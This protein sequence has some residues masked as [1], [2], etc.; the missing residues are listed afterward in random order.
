MKEKDSQIEDAMEMP[1]I[2]VT[3][4]DIINRLIK[5]FGLTS[6][7]E[8]NK[9]DGASYYDEIV[10]Q[11]KTIAYLPENSFLDADNIQRLLNIAK[12][13]PMEQIMTLDQLI[14]CYGSE[15]FD[16]IFFDPVHIRP[17]VD[18]ALQCLPR[19]LNPGGFL[20]VHDCNPELEALT[21][22][23]R[24]SGSWVGETYKAMTLFRH[25]NRTQ[26]VTVAEDHG[27]G[28]IYN[29]GLRLDYDLDFDIDYYE[30]AANRESYIGLMTFQAFLDRTANGDVGKLL[31][32]D[33]TSVSEPVYFYA[34]ASTTDKVLPHGVSS[35]SQKIVESQLFWCQADN[36]FAE[37]N[38]VINK[39]WL[40]GQSQTLRFTLPEGAGNLMCLRFDVFD[41][42]G[43]ATLEAV[44]VFQPG[45]QLIWEWQQD[46]EDISWLSDPRNLALHQIP[47]TLLLIADSK[48]PRVLLDLP[49][50]IL[51]DLGPG[52][53][54]EIQISPQTP[55]QHA[56]WN[57]L[58]DCQQRLVVARDENQQL[59][60]RLQLLENKIGLQ[61][62]ALPLNADK[63]RITAQ[64]EIE[65]MKGMA[66]LDCLRD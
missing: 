52:C 27:V 56:L 42:P 29:Q 30:F 49:E 23:V 65:G 28:I 64:A 61:Q 8:Y 50:S 2:K 31:A 55:I 51:A 48:D 26:S 32:L 57:Q 6:Y 22:K 59:Q 47:G 13:V 35:I 44:R 33:A 9:F 21:T 18:Q 66:F 10:C 60:Q 53:M 16:L 4:G 17:G 11:K 43:T 12:D 19:L 20:V 45:R 3:K 1:L 62:Q 63:P 38:S 39:L 7:F 14:E 24:R 37:S 15:K 58:T 40:N 5:Q 46:N 36:T 41:C 54:L 25:H 34:L